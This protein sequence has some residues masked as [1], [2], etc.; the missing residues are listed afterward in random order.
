MLGVV[1]IY[2][3]VLHLSLIVIVLEV[4]QPYSPTLMGGVIP[5]FGSL[6]LLNTK[7][8]SSPAYSRK[9]KSLHSKN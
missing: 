7:I 1:S 8:H 6:L 4:L 5:V 2:G 3:K 9:K